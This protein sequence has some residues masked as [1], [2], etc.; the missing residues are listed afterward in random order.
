[1]AVE[2]FFKKIEDK[3]NKELEFSVLKYFNP[4][5]TLFKILLDDDTQFTAEI[6]TSYQDLINSREIQLLYH[7]LFTKNEIVGAISMREILH[8]ALPVQNENALN[9]FFKLNKNSAYKSNPPLGTNC[10]KMQFIYAAGNKANLI[11]NDL[12]KGKNISGKY[13]MTFTKHQ[14]FDSKGRYSNLVV[15]KIK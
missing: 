14:K 9:E 15:L 2:E 3:L 5:R 11:I 6:I 10:G 1:M 12:A 13:E 7:K 4:D 8:D